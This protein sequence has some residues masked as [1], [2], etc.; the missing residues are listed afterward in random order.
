MPRQED[1]TKLLIN[2]NRRLQ[3]LR[4]RK[5]SFGLD[6][7]V[8]VLT[9]IQDTEAEIEK[10]QTE[11]AELNADLPS[12]TST[13][14]SDEISDESQTPPQSQEHD[15]KTK[16]QELGLETIYITS[17]SPDMRTRV[18]DLILHSQHIAWVGTAINLLDVASI[19][20]ILIHRAQSGKSKVEICLANPYSRQVND[21]LNEEEIESTPISGRTGI[22]KHINGLI[23][24]RARKAIPNSRLEIRLFNHYPTVALLIFDS[25]LIVYHYD[26]HE[27]GNLSPAFCYHRGIGSLA[28]YY[29]KVYERIKRDSIPAE[30]VI[31]EHG[32]LEHSKNWAQELFW[33]AIYLIPE[34]TSKFYQKWSKLVGYDIREKKLL[35][36]S[37]TLE[38]FRGDAYTFGCHITVLD[39]M[40]VWGKSQLDVICEELRWLASQ[41]QPISLRSLGY[42]KDFKKKA[43][44]VEFTD[45]SGQLESLHAELIVRFATQAATSNYQIKG[46]P[47]ATLNMDNPRIHHMIERFHTPFC[48]NEFRPHVTVLGDLQDI[49]IDK[50]RELVIEAGG[51]IFED[52]N[53]PLR[54]DEICLMILSDDGSWQIAEPPI[55]LGK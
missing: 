31:R 35:P 1:I 15:F 33:F 44:V 55:K 2:S 41:Y 3:A 6:T 32:Q 46:H 22:I 42:P 50:A 12:Q 49:S 38:K 21:R 9:E 37:P 14:K 51:K 28:D 16:R 18:E 26:Y 30:L 13:I 45:D 54:F 40:G 48:L 19:R 8:A 27:L 20:D 47:A 24:I 36:P 34:D 4:E 53:T 23:N 25:H 5:A 7:P 29:L 43:L 39:A 52:K 17:D 11:L 10:L